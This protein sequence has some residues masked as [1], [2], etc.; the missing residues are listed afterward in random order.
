MPAEHHVRDRA[1]AGVASD[2]GHGDIKKLRD[3]HGGEQ[4]IGAA[5][6]SNSLGGWPLL[7]WR[8]L[9]EQGWSGSLSV[10]SLAGLLVGVCWLCVQVGGWWGCLLA[11]P[12]S[13]LECARPLGG[14]R[15]GSRAWFCLRRFCWRAASARPRA[16][17]CRLRCR[18]TPLGVCALGEGL[19]EGDR[20]R[21]LVRARPCPVA[22]TSEIG[23]SGL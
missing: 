11:Q 8:W 16:A 9:D 2:P 21:P 17:H 13:P 18:S 23:M 5:R 6:A 14:R 3:P 19:V 4:T 15:A 20:E 1:A 12:S 22:L 10:V 7:G